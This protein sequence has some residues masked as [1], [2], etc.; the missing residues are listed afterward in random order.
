M[1]AAKTI[2]GPWAAENPQPTTAVANPPPNNLGLRF[3]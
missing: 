1:S 2:G 3:R